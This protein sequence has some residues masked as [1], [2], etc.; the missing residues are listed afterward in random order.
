MM[1]AGFSQA[2]SHLSS[3]DSVRISQSTINYHSASAVSI[4]TFLT[5]T[6]HTCLHIKNLACL[7]SVSMLTVLFCFSFKIRQIIRVQ[8]SQRSPIHW[9]RP[10]NNTVHACIPRHFHSDQPNCFFNL[11]FANAI[12]YRLEWTIICILHVSWLFSGF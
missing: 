6:W 10:T 1:L 8:L 3:H 5:L 9:S 7:Y 11:W 2:G 4:N 12:Y